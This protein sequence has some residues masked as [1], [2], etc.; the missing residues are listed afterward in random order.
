MSLLGSLP[1]F[2][3]GEGAGIPFPE[4]LEMS[5]AVFSSPSFLDE[6]WLFGGD[7]DDEDSST[8]FH[9]TMYV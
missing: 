4:I 2:K 9:S 7:D 1:G 6:D 3:L 8:A 5:A